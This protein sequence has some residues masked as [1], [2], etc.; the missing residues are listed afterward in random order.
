MADEAEDDEVHFGQSQVQTAV[1]R[2]EIPR[3]IRECHPV[4]K[5]PSSMTDA[6]H[7]FFLIST[8]RTIGDSLWALVVGVV[9]IALMTGLSLS[10][11]IVISA[12]ASQDLFKEPSS[13]RPVSN[14]LMS[15]LA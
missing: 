4:A 12:D 10:L 8:Q 9:S 1:L 14:N 5:V 13:H 6:Q 3:H 15:I 2:L 7:N 11:V